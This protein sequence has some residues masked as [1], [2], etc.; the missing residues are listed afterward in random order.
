MRHA[1][2]GMFFVSLI[3]CGGNPLNSSTSSAVNEELAAIRTEKLMV[4]IQKAAV[5]E[6]E[7]D[8]AVN[9]L[10]HVDRS[11]GLCS[12]S[13]KVTNYM[14]YTRHA[15]HVSYYGVAFVELKYNCETNAATYI[16]RI[17]EDDRYQLWSNPRIGRLPNIGVSN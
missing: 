5:A 17:S 12:A 9:Q 3:A 14:D 6:D 4:S 8:E 10:N 13:A 16:K 1:I 15:P 7:I 11:T 2:L